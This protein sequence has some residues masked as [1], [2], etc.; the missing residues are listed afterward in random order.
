MSLSTYLRRPPLGYS[1]QEKTDWTER[2]QPQGEHRCI[3]SWGELSSQPVHSTREAESWRAA[4]EAETGERPNPR[5]RESP[6]NGLLSEGPS[7]VSH[8]KV[9]FAVQLF[10]RI[11]LCATPYTAAQQASLS[12]T[13]FRSLL[14]LMSIESV[15]PSNHF[16]LCHPLL[17]LPSIFPSI[18]AFP[19]DL[20]LP[21]KWP[22]YWSFSFSI[23]LPINIQDWFPLGWTGWISLQSKGLSG[24]FPNT[25]VQKHQ[26]LQHSTFFMIQLSHPYMTTEKTTALTIW[27]FVSKVMSPLFNMLSRF[28]N[29]FSSKEQVSFTFFRQIYIP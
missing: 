3:A 5:A 12:F 14:K 29:S 6:W 16:I 11:L 28:V 24:V 20:A 1:G 19:N 26:I 18:M 22:K 15:M 25:I 8:S 23:I 21:I 27:I 13:I 17:L 4:E 2:S 9:V 10:S 7:K